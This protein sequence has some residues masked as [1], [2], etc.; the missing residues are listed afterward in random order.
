VFPT[1][2]LFRR[3]DNPRVIAAWQFFPL[4]VSAAQVIYSSVR[5]RWS[6]AR[7][8]QER[9][10][11]TLAQ[12]MLFMGF[13]LSAASHVSLLASA[14]FSAR[15]SISSTLWYLYVPQLQPTLP[16]NV[17][18]TMGSLH[19]LRWDG[20]FCW[21]PTLMAGVLS[22]EDT[23]SFWISVLLLPYATLAFGPGA[24]VAGLWIWREKVLED[25]GKRAAAES[26]DIMTEKESVVL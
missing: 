7:P 5:A 6:A 12:T 10:G 3:P 22:L 24:A 9:S 19:L 11:Y 20:V 17:T 14:F 13:I 15:D 21:L 1:V 16:P 8:D 4:Y 26:G 25:R 2:E 23:Q 18:I